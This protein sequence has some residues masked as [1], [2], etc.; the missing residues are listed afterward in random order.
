MN[1]KLTPT[2]TEDFKKANGFLNF[3]VIL[4]DN[5]GIEHS[6]KVPVFGLYIDN[7]GHKAILSKPEKA[8]E[9]LKI[10]ITGIHVI[11]EEKEIDL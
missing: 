1:K 3:K 4:T 11:E 10:E 7:K 2:T 9:N 8:M 5:K 6:I